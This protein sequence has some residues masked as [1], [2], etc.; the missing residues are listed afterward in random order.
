MTI[1]AADALMIIAQ[2]KICFGMIK[3][4]RHPRGLNMTIFAFLPHAIFVSIVFFVTIN[5]V[6]FGK[7]IKPV[8]FMAS[9]AGNGDVIAS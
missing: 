5:A 4:G 9:L 6:M 7:A 8:F 3:K 2:W 1:L